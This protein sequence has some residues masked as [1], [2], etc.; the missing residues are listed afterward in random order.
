MY[1]GNTLIL[2][3]EN[4][5]AMYSCNEMCKVKVSKKDFYILK[6]C[7]QDSLNLPMEYTE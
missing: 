2:I 3:R 4:T 1:S 6:K 7:G 5:H